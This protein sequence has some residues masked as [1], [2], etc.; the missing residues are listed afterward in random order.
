MDPTLSARNTTKVVL[1]N[2]GE[3][4]P[5]PVDKSKKSLLESAHK[6]I[7]PLEKNRFPQWRKE[8]SPC[9]TN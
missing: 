5:F 4:D 9:N 7:S 6:E 3:R 2:G 1:K 8:T